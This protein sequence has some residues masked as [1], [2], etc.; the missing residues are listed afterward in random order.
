M[1]LFLKLPPVGRL[2]SVSHSAE[3]IN[4]VSSQSR[5]LLSCGAVTFALGTSSCGLADGFADVGSSLG[6]PDAALLDSPGRKLASGKFHSLLIDGSLGDGGHVIALQHDEGDSQKLAIIPYV[7]GNPC[8][9]EPAHAFDRL[10]SR[11]DV[12]LPGIISLQENA[13]DTGRGRIR[14]LDFSCKELFPGLVDSTLPRVPFPASNPTGLLALEGDGSL[15]VVEA[16]S[17]KVQAIAAGV[18]LARSAAD[19]LWTIEDK[20]L[21]IRDVKLDVIGELGD[22]VTEYATTGGNKISVAFQDKNGLNVWSEEEGV[23]TLSK[24]ACGTVAWGSDTI[25]YFDPC[26]ERRLNIYTLGDRV[27]SDEE[28][29]QIVGPK[30]TVM[31]DRGSVYWGN[32]KRTTE[33]TFLIENKPNDT[34]L[35]LG[36]IL[37]EPE[38]SSQPLELLTETLIEESA[39]IRQ[40]NIFK[41]WNGTTGTLV[42]VER[43]DD[44]EISGLVTIAD[45]VAQLPAGSAYSHRGVLANFE[46]GLGELRVFEKDSSESILVSS[47]VPLQS[48]SVEPETGRIAFVGDSM[49]GVSGILYLTRALSAGGTQEKPQ[50]LDENVLVDTARFL[51]Q[52]RALAYLVRPEGME[53]AEL[54][55][56]LIDSGLKL[57]ID[58]QVSEYRTVPWPAPGILYAVPEGKEQ[59]LWF[60]KAR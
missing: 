22:E 42:E 48:Q 49:N 37:E 14:F 25:A 19:L 38:A 50:R 26:E 4:R 43:D 7:E 45:G 60:S 12:E 11:I 6:N 53:F 40:A 54:R 9:V 31:L 24:S 1:P 39:T 23:T 57:T 44:G 13:D 35:A 3:L 2:A 27:G 16:R 47:G 5:R 51:E 28:F 10:S 33:I 15:S 20:K 55:V 32:G 34:S 21:V 58:P 29:L 56:W 59:G 17:Q 36:R 46:N 41:D 8:F 30:D 52:P 18:S